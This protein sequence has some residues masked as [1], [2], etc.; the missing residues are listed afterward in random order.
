MTHSLTE[1]RVSPGTQRMSERTCEMDP[2]ITEKTLEMKRTLYA[3]CWLRQRPLAQHRL[4]PDQR[5]D[6]VMSLGP[7]IALRILTYTAHAFDQVGISDLL[8]DAV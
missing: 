3:V 5:L 4:V 8:D 7:R 1:L 2:K 6:E